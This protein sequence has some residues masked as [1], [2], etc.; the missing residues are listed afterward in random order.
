[1]LDIIE[2]VHS[3]LFTIEGSMATIGIVMEILFRFIPS[4]KPMGILILVASSLKGV[5]EILVKTSVI[6]DKVIPQKIK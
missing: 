5:G 1:M 6:L 3:F 4:E 2:K